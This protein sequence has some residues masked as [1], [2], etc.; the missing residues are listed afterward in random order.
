[1]HVL[2]I[3][4][5]YFAGINFKQYWLC[6]DFLHSCVHCFWHC[7]TVWDTV[8]Y[9]PVP[10]VCDQNPNTICSPILWLVLAL[11]NFLKRSIGKPKKNKTR[12][13]CWFFKVSNICQQTFQ[14]NE[15]QLANH[16]IWRHCFHT[17]KCQ[18]KFQ[19][20]EERTIWLVKMFRFSWKV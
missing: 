16:A 19:T 3:N 17:F 6:S 13:K 8:Y 7:F 15:I 2:C 20:S 18:K 12:K 10:K 14:N 4:H 1:M 11:P 5:F 9:R